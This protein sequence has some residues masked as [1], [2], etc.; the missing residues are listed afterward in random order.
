MERMEAE[1][2]EQDVYP[3]AGLH[4]ECV[5]WMHK[6]QASVYGGDCIENARPG[7]FTDVFFFSVQTLG[8]IGYGKMVPHNVYANVLVTVEVL[9]GL[10]GFA[11]ATGLF[12]TKFARPTARVMFSKV[13]VVSKRDGVPHL[14]FRMANERTNQIVDRAMA[15]PVVPSETTLLNT[16]NVPTG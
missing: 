14:M 9:T 6:R 2:G 7:S 13:M 12:F 8:T 4:A 1:L 16:T 10:L 5:E 11:L 3:R 15:P